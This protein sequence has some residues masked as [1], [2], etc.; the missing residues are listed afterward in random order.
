MG[1]QK[2]AADILSAGGEDATKL[3]DVVGQTFTLVDFEEK[4]SKKFNSVFVLIEALTES[5]DDILLMGGGHLAPKLRQ[6]QR[7]G[8]LNGQLEVVVTTFPTDKGNDGYGLEIP[9]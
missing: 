7:H 2:S 6:L 9:E 8:Y 5:G 3:K 4:E 1:N